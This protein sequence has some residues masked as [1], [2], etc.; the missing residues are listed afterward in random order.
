MRLNR[1]A[2]LLGGAML[3]ACVAPV[4]AQ[5]KAGS[6][7]QRC[8]ALA[9]LALRDTKIVSA[10]FVSAGPY[11]GEN[12]PANA[13]KILLPEHCR[14]T[15][16]IRPAARSNIGFQLWL[17]ARGWNGKFQ[18]AGNGGFAG[19]INYRGGLIEGVARGY[20]VVS[21]DT[22]HVANGWQRP[23][24]RAIST[25]RSTMAI[26]ASI[27]RRCRAR[28]SPPLSTAAGHGSPS[29]VPARTAAARR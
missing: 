1:N 16:T 4:A 21:T 3:I 14:V 6:A 2:A 13:T 28:R 19:D 8:A 20:A 26:A 23:G 9:Q 18:G 12:D 27:S 7:T 24:R 10:M 15:G 25:R 5:A 17:P 22:G 29:S 11:V